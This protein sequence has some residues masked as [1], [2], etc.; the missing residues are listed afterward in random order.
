LEHFRRHGRIDRPR[1]HGDDANCPR[2]IL[3]RSALCEADHAVLGCV[4]SCA[5]EET[6]M[7]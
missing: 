2:S 6:L 5:T 4:L 1:A 7:K 3:K